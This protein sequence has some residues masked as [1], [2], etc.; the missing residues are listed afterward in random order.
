MLAMQNSEG[1][2]TLLA[3]KHRILTL[4]MAAQSTKM[5]T[6]RNTHLDA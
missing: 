6:A 5:E 2:G 1:G 4:C 3:Y